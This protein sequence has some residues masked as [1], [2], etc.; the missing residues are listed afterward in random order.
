MRVDHG[1]GY[2]L[3]GRLQ[4]QRRAVLDT[5]GR[6]IFTAVPSAGY[7][8]SCGIREDATLACVGDDAASG[9]ATPPAGTFRFP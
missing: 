3:L 4:L 6:A 8:H 5:A 9:G 2:R 1:R 7:D